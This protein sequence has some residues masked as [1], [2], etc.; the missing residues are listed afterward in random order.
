MVRQRLRNPDHTFPWRC[1][2]LIACSAYMRKKYEVVGGGQLPELSDMR[3]DPMA[4]GGDAAAGNLNA[5]A[6]SAGEISLGVL[7]YS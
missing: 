4:F 7:F 3:V 1:G 6:V 5:Q 2:A